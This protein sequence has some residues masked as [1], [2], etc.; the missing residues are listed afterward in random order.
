MVLYFQLTKSEKLST[1]ICSSCISI[2]AKYATT[3][4]LFLKNQKKLNDLLLQSDPLIDDDHFVKVEVMETKPC[5]VI[6]FRESTGND[7]K[8]ITVQEAA[9]L[10]MA[11]AKKK[12]EQ[13]ISNRPKT[14]SNR[15]ASARLQTSKEKPI[16]GKGNSSD[17]DFEDTFCG[18]S[19][20]SSS[21]PKPKELDVPP[22]PPPFAQNKPKLKKV[23][24]YYYCDEC[25]T[26]PKHRSCQ[27]YSLLNH[28]WRV[29]G[30]E[31]P[32]RSFICEMCPKQF[33]LKE[34]LKRHHD[35]HNNVKRFACGKLSFIYFTAF[36]I[37]DFLQ[38]FALFKHTAG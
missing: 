37:Y 25:D 11:S 27:M 23:K 33:F 28:K 26:S 34:Q 16:D 3:R 29:H 24:G 36:L 5:T 31:E 2:L 20:S 35:M 22:M 12:I 7:S 14:G 9:K 8:Q 4:K 32:A 38:I 6:E 10:I 17:E 15:R 13:S 21:S 1:K 30:G 18:G 19:R